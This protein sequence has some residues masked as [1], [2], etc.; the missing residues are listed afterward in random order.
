MNS[1]WVVRSPCLEEEVL[2]LLARSVDDAFLVAPFIKA[3]VFRRI[4]AV[5]PA[6]VSVTVIT[7]WKLDEIASGV[8]DLEVWTSVRNRQH[9]RMLLVGNLHAKVFISDRRALVGSA[10]LTAAALAGSSTGNLELLIEVPSAQPAVASV[11]QTALSAGVPVTDARFDA[12][13]QARDQIVALVPSEDDANW[14]P[15]LRNPKDLL[16][17][18]SERS[19]FTDWQIAQA[20]EDLVL[21]GIRSP[22]GVTDD[23]VGLSLIEQALVC[24]LL[25]FV[26]IEEGRRF[27]ELTEWLRVGYGKG[28]TEAQTLIRWVV[29]FLP[30]VFEY[31]RPRYTEVLRRVRT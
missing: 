29:H 9:S 8:S 21:L 15:T 26:D 31:S 22:S 13:V 19:C 30:D 14:F 23:L 12:M 6:E 18:A 28:P 20:K 10:N 24:Q 16:S 4:L 27:G 5:I 11:L 25:H 2:E 17:A 3:P 1:G 7:R